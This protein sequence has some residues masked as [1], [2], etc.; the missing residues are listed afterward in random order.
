MSRS[1]ILSLV[2]FVLMS[3]F[4]TFCGGGSQRHW[5]VVKGDDGFPRVDPPAQ[6]VDPERRTVFATEYFWSEFLG[7]ELR[8]SEDTLTVNGVS[9]E[10]LESKVAL[11]ATL[12]GSVPEETIGKASK[13]LINNLTR[14]DSGE[15][16]PTVREQMLLL[17]EKYLYDPN[18]P[19]RNA[20]A[21]AIIAGDLAQ[22]PAIDSL[23]REIYSEK[24]KICSLNKEGTKASDFSFVSPD[25]SVRNLYSVK[26]KY[27]LLVFSNPGCQMCEDIQKAIAT[28]PKL[29]KLQSDGTI[30]IVNIYPDE[31]EISW[32]K[33]L[34]DYP[35]EWICGIDQAQAL[36]GDHLY[37]LR[38]IPSLYLLGSNKL[39]I[40][41]DAPLW[42]VLDKINLMIL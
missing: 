25:G 18:S 23:Q 36:R 39:V 10:T 31:D 33:A 13:N 24:A 28:S 9:L 15:A 3:A 26:A 6:I 21:F 11:W 5:V 20:A 41:R 32:R 12:L 2:L 22:C 16:Q 8:W 40:L 19:L 35:R 37:D 34:K 7:Q 4:L 29:Q 27:T 42:M 17:V 1:T 38:A 14:P 30:A